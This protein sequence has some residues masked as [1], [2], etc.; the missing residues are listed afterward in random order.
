MHVCMGGTEGWPGSG[1][2]EHVRLSRARQGR[3]FQKMFLSVPNSLTQLGL[4]VLL[5]GG[6]QE[7]RS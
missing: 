3:A 7:V 2:E 4:Q 6:P 5:Q 1:L